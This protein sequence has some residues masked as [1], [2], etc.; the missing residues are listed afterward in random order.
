VAAHALTGLT[1]QQ[2]EEK[3]ISDAD[4]A[5]QDHAGHRFWAPK[6]EPLVGEKEEKSANGKRKADDADD[7]AQAAKR[8]KKLTRDNEQVTRLA[9]DTYVNAHVG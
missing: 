1:A 6:P 2:R 4:I 8:M 5:D 7:K 3:H 9:Y